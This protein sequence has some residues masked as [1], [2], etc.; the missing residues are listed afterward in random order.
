MRF[1]TEQDVA[2]LLPLDAAV[3]CVRRA[4][5]DHAAGLALDTPRAR[6]RTRSGCL[7]ILQAASTALDVI[8][9]KAY[10]PG[11]QWRVFHVQLI[12]LS[13][14]APLALIEADE[15]GIRRTGA[16][17]AVA[18]QALAR[19]DASVVA[20]FGSGRHGLTQLRAVCAVRSI[21]S[22]RVHGRN[23]VRLE[24]FACAARRALGLD[25]SIAGSA[26][27]AL[28]GADIVNIVTRAPAPL[29]DGA[30]LQAGQHVNAVGSNAL[31]RREIDLPAVRRAD[32]LVVD[33]VDVA[34]N[35]SGDLLPAIEAGL[36]H[37]H[38]VTE[39][40][41]VLTGRRPGRTSADS[42][43]LF[44]SHG[45]GILDLYAAQHVF[46]VAQRHDVGTLLPIAGHPVSG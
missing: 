29:F 24:G 14:G 31:G 36:L 30:L 44:E 18:T 9:F 43:S 25:V 19:P 34:R 35:E 39:L 12:R 27:E 17:T 40:G 8:G 13:T 5:Q 26:Q 11:R 6:T 33:S 21:R 42:I 4:F 3:D 22:V 7:H 15:L 32:V 2:A 20:C 23:R 1:L 45:M 41:Q 46:E 37:W 16:A 28:E 38:Q 10:F